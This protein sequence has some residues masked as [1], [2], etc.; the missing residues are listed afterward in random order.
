LFSITLDLVHTKIIDINK[1]IS[2]LTINP[3]KIL[4]IDSP[5]LEE[6]KVADF[7]V[8]DENESHTIKQENLKTS[9]TPFDGNKVHG[10]ILATYINGEVAF[11]NQIF[12]NKIIQ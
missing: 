8:F 5:S 4:G 3:A 10:K 11:M 9:P 1:A 12:K 6:E 2:F 7:I